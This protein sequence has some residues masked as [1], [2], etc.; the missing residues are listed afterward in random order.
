[1]TVYHGGTRGQVQI[2]SGFQLW[3]WR[4]ESQIAIADWVLQ[5]AW[6][7]PRQNIPR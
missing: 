7:I 4:R 1:M 6:G 3:Y 2:F 5:H